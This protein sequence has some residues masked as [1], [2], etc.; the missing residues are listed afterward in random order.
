MSKWDE[1]FSA[2][3]EGIRECPYTKECDAFDWNDGWEAAFMDDRP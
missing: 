3:W 2:Y 1:G